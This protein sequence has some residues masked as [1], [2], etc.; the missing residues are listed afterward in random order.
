MNIKHIPKKVNS[1]NVKLNTNSMQIHKKTIMKN[2]HVWKRYQMSRFHV[3]KVRQPALQLWLPW[4][5]LK[6]Y[7]LWCIFPPLRRRGVSRTDAIAGFPPFPPTS[8]CVRMSHWLA[9]RAHVVK[10]GSVIACSALSPS[11]P[12]LS[13]FLC[14][15][16]LERHPFRSALRP[17]GHCIASHGVAL[18][19]FRFSRNREIPKNPKSK[20]FK[21]SKSLRNLPGASYVKRPQCKG[22]LVY[23]NSVTAQYLVLQTPLP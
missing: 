4:F 14:T 23:R 20:F 9:K 5:C 10:C 22:P 2:G 13:S 12:Y 17:Q 15:L 3:H 21:N 1:K 11:L 16:S 8:R 7:S 6:A 19:Y 18:V